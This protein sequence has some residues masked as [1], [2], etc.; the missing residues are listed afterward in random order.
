MLS[1]RDAS[2]SA[3]RVFTE[4]PV[5]RA[6]SVQHPLSP[7]TRRRTAGT[8]CRPRCLYTRLR[9]GSRSPF[10]GGGGWGVGGTLP[11]SELP[12][13]SRGPTL[14]AAFLGTPVSGLCVNSSAHTPNPEGDL[15]CK[16]AARTPE[17]THPL[18]VPP[19]LLP[20][21]PAPSLASSAAPAGSRLRQPRGSQQVSGFPLFGLSPVSS[22]YSSTQETQIW[23]IL[24]DCIFPQDTN[25]KR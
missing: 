9:T 25:I 18:A 17:A 12:D 11:R 5:P 24:P 7:Q 16:P 20:P 22:K 6:P 13:A 3:P 1:S 4:R 14:E 8:Q 21:P 23:G 19:Q 15:T 2:E 10:L